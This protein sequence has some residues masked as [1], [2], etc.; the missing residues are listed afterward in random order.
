M[1][2]YMYVCIT[3]CS[4]FVTQLF[5]LLHVWQIYACVHPFKLNIYI[6][7]YKLNIYIYIYIYIHTHTY[8]HTHNTHKY[9]YKY[10]H[11]HTHTRTYT[12]ALAGDC[13]VYIYTYIHTYSCSRTRAR[14]P[15]F[16]SLYTRHVHAY[17]WVGDVAVALPA[18]AL[19][20]PP[21]LQCIGSVTYAHTCAHIHA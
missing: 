20:T 4:E 3:S 14:S 2:T 10:T 18:G 9:F 5:Q 1:Y 6:Y 15:S 13:H 17:M 19:C 12:Q 8:M 11:T 16:T 7:I 21:V